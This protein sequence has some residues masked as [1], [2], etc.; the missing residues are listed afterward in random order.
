VLTP[1]VEAEVTN[2]LPMQGGTDTEDDEQLRERILDAFQGRGAG[3][4][5]DYRAWARAYPGVGRATVIPL[6][7]GPGTVLVIVTTATGGQVSQDVIDGLQALLD[8]I[9]GLAEGD[10]PVGALVTVQTATAK[11][12]TL[13]GTI[14]FEGGY[15]L[16]GA[17]AT[18]AL[19]EDIQDAVDIYVTSVESGGE[20]VLMQIGARIGVIPGVHEVGNL[21]LDGVAANVTLDDNPPEV[22]FIQTYTLVEGAL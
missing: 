18:I 9:P 11:P 19:Q 16:D 21:K 8:P 6:W 4:A 10:A 12:L 7:D 17:G 13:A 14:E 22:A 20:V 2:P 5:R 1:G 3:S 15:S